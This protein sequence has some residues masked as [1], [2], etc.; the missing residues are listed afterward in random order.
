LDQ[1]A[2]GYRNAM[3]K[4]PRDIRLH[5][6]LGSLEESRGN[7]QQAQTLYQQALLIKSDDPAISNNLAYLLIEHGG[8][9]NL[10]MS[11]AQTARKGL[12]HLASTADTLGW[13]YYY[14]G[15]FPSAVST[16]QMA[17]KDSPENPTFHYHLGL[18]YQKTNDSAHA[19]EQFER[20]ME[21]HPAPQQADE[22]RKALGKNAGG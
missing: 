4:N 8:D 20:A 19:K 11:L 3:Q 12:P 1:A 18:A 14:Q 9:K 22:I 16:L 5:L 15:L 21:L 13:A 17:I 10:A 2:A 7:W 6:G